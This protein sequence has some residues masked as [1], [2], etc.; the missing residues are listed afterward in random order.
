MVH[1]LLSGG[2]D[3]NRLVGDDLRKEERFQS[4]VPR[5]VRMVKALQPLADELGW[6]VGQLAIAWVMAH[7]AV[8]SV[9]VGA[10]SPEQAAENARPAIEGIPVDLRRRVEE[11]LGAQATAS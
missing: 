9:I 2:F 5:T 7:P 4:L 8:T 10:R 6:T 1:G 3:P 11:A